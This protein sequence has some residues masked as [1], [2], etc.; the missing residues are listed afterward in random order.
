ML[1]VERIDRASLVSRRLAVRGAGRVNAV[2][3][4]MLHE[5]ARLTTRGKPIG[6]RRTDAARIAQDQPRTGRRIVRRLLALASARSVGCQAIA[7]QP[8]ARVDG[9]V[10][11]AAAAEPL[12]LRRLPSPPARRP[13]RSPDSTFASTR[14]GLGFESLDVRSA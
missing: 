4:P 3:G 13:P 1:F 14:S 11:A 5:H 6:E 7:I 8:L 12:H 9:R 2:L 10:A